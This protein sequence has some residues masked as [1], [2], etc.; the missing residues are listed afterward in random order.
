MGPILP[1]NGPSK[2]SLTL[3][4][5]EIFGL[6]KVTKYPDPGIQTEYKKGSDWYQKGTNACMIPLSSL[7]HVCLILIW[8]ITVETP[9]IDISRKKRLRRG[10]YFTSKI[11]TETPFPAATNKNPPAVV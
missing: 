4:I 6:L 11:H 9:K 3:A 8:L 10:S 2:P 7:F 1:D 5:Q